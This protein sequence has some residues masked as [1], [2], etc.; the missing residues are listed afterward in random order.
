MSGRLDDVESRLEDG[1]QY[2]D[3][4]EVPGL[5]LPLTTKKVRQKH[6]EA[7]DGTMAKL[8][9][10]GLEASGGWSNQMARAIS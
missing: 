1:L 2:F 6:E 3:E 9:E 7:A 5:P 8:L 10:E 4:D